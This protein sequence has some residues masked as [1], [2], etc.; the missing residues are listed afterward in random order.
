MAADGGGGDNQKEEGDGE[1]EDGEKGEQEMAEAEPDEE[2][3]GAEVGF[4]QRIW[5]LCVC[6]YVVGLCGC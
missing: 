4:Y 5:G 2:A 1:G 6:M 3:G